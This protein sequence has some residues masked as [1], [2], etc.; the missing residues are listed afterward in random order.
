MGVAWVLCAGALLLGVL[1]LVTYVATSR[2]AG[3]DSLV[4]SACRP[5]LTRSPT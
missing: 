4:S 2:V 1:G 3:R 5:A